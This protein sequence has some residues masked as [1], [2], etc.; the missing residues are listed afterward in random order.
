MLSCFFDDSGKESAIDNQ[1]VVI[2]G[3]VASED[4]WKIF[5]GMW[6][7]S[8]LRFGISWLHTKDFVCGQG[9]YAS[10]GWDWPTR[11][12]MLE[13]FLNLIR[14]SHLTAFA[15]AIDMDAWREFPQE[16]ARKF[17]NAHGFCFAR[18][19]GVVVERMKT[20]APRDIASVSFDCDRAI[21]PARLQRF[22]EIRD[23]I[24][25]AHRY[26]QSFSVA[27][28][29]T[30]CPLQAADL[31]AWEA[32]TE[33]VRKIKKL[34]SRQEFQLLMQVPFDLPRHIYAEYMG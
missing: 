23:G 19:L 8:L 29:R 26:L 21:T 5:T 22:L 33:F 3:F 27:E 13:D 25:E 17:G 15:V 24:L 1:I 16:R 9:E 2:A 34:D 31:L 6:L 30:S 18:I 7:N 20:S 12:L 10:R 28:P 32:R 4:I 11:K 14:H